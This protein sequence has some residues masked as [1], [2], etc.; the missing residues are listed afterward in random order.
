[1]MLWGGFAR[2]ASLSLFLCVCCA[3]F[4]RSKCGQIRNPRG[5]EAPSPHKEGVAN[6]AVGERP[7]QP[8]KIYYPVHQRR[9][10]KVKMLGGF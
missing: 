1:M 2:V 7:R 4:Q 3:T 10:A 8:M 6:E 9:R 5:E